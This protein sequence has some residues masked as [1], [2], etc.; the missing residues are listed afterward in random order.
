MFTGNEMNMFF[1]PITPCECCRMKMTSCTITTH[2]WTKE[3]IKSTVIEL[4]TE[5]SSKKWYED[6]SYLKERLK[7]WCKK[8][9]V[10]E[11]V[12]N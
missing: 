2:K 4:A 12:T 1:N 8:L 5:L 3:E 10:L 7:H 11:E 9:E 6:K